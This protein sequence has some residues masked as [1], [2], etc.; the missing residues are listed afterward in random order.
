MQQVLIDQFSATIR[1]AAEN[2]QPLNIRSGG[3]K[4][5]YGNPASEQAQILDVS[6]YQGIIDY[7]PTELVITARAGTPL[8]DIESLLHQHKQM[9]AF[10]PPHFADTATLGG[11]IAAGL[12]GPRRASTGAARDFVLGVRILDGT[13]HDLHFGG[14]VMKNV[15]G[16]DVSRLMVGAMGTL[17]ILLEISLK[18]LPLP[19]VEQ[20]VCLEIN[21]AEAI[22][23]M[24]RWAGRPLPI[25][26]TC[27]INGQLY[28]RLSGAESAVRAAQTQLGGEI[29]PAG[30][31]FWK[32]V[33][34]HAHDFFKPAVSLWRLS[35]KS[36]TPPLL[37]PQTKQLIEW[38]GALRW[39][40]C[41]E[42]QTAGSIRLAAQKTGGHAT[43]FR[44][45]T[46]AAPVFQPLNPALAG[47]H[48]RLKQ[49]FDPAGILNPGRLYPE[50]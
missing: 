27:Y 7:E 16:Y 32:S 10:E 2:S 46:S 18:V 22:E 49:Q 43:L 35:V 41:Q 38:N 37:F 23:Y 13:G 9:L 48:Q 33:R 20:T 15:A 34:E 39:I 29:Y 8:T 21:E 6:P 30:D 12:S 3:S 44:N 14:Q 42:K 17:G 36:T 11:C 31:A 19:V 40:N 1:A 4:S 26:A 45:H 5:F 24:N 25:S 50:F 47:I 28:M